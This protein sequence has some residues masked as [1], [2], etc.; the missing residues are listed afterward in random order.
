MLEKNHS[1]FFASKNTVNGFESNFDSIFSPPKFNQITILK[2]G[3][4]TGK[5]SF[6][7]SVAEAAEQIGYTVE[8]FLC[9]SDPN[10]LDGIL[11]RE[12]AI[13]IVDGTSPHTM[14]PIFPGVIENIINLGV[15]W[16]QKK[17]IENKSEI[18]E[19]IKDKKRF[20][21][22]AYQFLQAH[23]EITREI[24]STA[25][26]ALKKE[27]MEQNIQRQAEKLFKKK[28]EF[29]MEIRN[30]ASF[31]A[32]GFI[33]L[34][35]FEDLSESIYILEDVDFSAHL[36][37]EK[38]YRLAKEKEQKIVISFS[39]ELPE[40]PNAI[41]FPEYNSTFV[42]GKRDYEKEDPKKKYQ[43][44]NMKRFLDESILSASKQK[45]RFGKKCSDMLLNGA[46]DAFREA[47]E[48]HRSLEQY[49]IFAMD[50]EKLQKRKNE[51]IQSIF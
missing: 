51:F 21:K 11:I 7:N 6:M 24:A 14:E 23:G 38:L 25:K 33:T 36:Y 18:L 31:C 9:S 46:T 28:S 15:F 42:I 5:S 45:I 32:K 13:A 39:P 12:K 48:A 19:L 2:G 16:D 26:I 27:K 44:I 4:G 49:F 40:L 1:L 20:Y 29:E 30:I 47:A 22:R 50:F 41:Y 10:S 35:S 43:Y 17:L 37:L 8:R 34:S 3:P